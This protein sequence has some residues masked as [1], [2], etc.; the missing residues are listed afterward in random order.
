MTITTTYP[1]PGKAIIALEG[2]LDASTAVELQSE[3]G[4]VMGKDVR[5]VEIDCE[6][7]EYISSKGL[8]ILVSIHQELASK[9]GRLSLVGMNSNVS[10]VLKLTGLL[11]F[12]A[13]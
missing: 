11:K 6:K 3:A 7:L 13:K 4:I 9:E 10:E 12:F 1:E 8:R 5:D 2:E